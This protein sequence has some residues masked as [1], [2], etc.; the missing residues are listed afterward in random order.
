[1]FIILRVNITVFTGRTTVVCVDPLI[2]QKLLGLQVKD[3]IVIFD[4]A[5]NIEEVCTSVNSF[6]LTEETL[7]DERNKLKLASKNFG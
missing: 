1:M 3:H 5:H 7:I 6:S 4:E 2:R